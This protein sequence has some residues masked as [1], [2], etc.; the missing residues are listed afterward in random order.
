MGKYYQGKK[1]TIW[2]ELSLLNILFNISKSSNPILW[3]NFSNVKP[4]GKKLLREKECNMDLTP[5][6]KN[7]IWDLQV[8]AIQFYESTY[9]M[10]IWEVLLWINS[11]NYHLNRLICQISISL[12][13][14]FF[15]RSWMKKGFGEIYL[16]LSPFMHHS[17][18]WAIQVVLSSYNIVEISLLES[19]T[20]AP[21]D[22]LSH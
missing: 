9:Q 20:H 22:M 1:S 3:I 8:N 17:F 2:I 10:L 15:G 12:F 4:N 11:L 21:L 19:R 5:S 14:F 18:N 16:I 13:F 7:I 6:I